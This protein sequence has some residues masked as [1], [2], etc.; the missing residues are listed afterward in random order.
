MD[1][2]WTYI[3]LYKTKNATL[4]QSDDQPFSDWYEF[5]NEFGSTENDAFDFLKSLYSL[6]VRH[7][8]DGVVTIEE[9]SPDWVEEQ[10]AESRREVD[11]ANQPISSNYSV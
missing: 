11:D 8:R 5:F 2:I 6:I 9:F 10:F 4:F 1:E 7:E 3:P